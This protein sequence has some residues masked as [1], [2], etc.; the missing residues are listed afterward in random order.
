MKVINTSTGNYL[1]ELKE[2]FIHAQALKEIFKDWITG[3][4]NLSTALSWGDLS[5][6][7][8]NDENILIRDNWYK[9]KDVTMLLC[10]SDDTIVGAIK[11]CFIDNPNRTGFQVSHAAIHPNYR[12]Q[13]LF[14]DMFLIISWFANQ[15]FEAAEGYYLTLDTAPAV[16]HKANQR[17]VTKGP[18]SETVL[19]TQTQQRLEKQAYQESFAVEE[20]SPI[21]LVVNDTIILQGLRE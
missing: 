9:F 3:S 5:E 10:K 1:T 12:G 21:Q 18:T 17:A 19:Y 11:Y 7:R 15:Y 16:E 14:S 2:D 8:L 6:N 4:I 13:G 20:F